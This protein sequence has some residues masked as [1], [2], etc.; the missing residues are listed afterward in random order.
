MRLAACV[1]DL[2]RSRWVIATSS[3]E[4]SM[5]S[6]R[7]TTFKGRLQGVVHQGEGGGA[8]REWL[9]LDHAPP[10]EEAARLVILG[11]DG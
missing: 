1:R 8:R 2:A 10:R 4:S 3:R 6:R 7:I 9:V 5:R 11:V